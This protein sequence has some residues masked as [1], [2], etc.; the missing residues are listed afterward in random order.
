MSIPSRISA[1][2]DLGQFFSFITENE[3]DKDSNLAKF[4]YLQDEFNAK[5]ELKSAF[6]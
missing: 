3:I 5:L 1:I 6:S 2:Y 4:K